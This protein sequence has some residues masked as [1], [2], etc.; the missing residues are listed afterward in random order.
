MA[1]AII[2]CGGPGTAAAAQA[3]TLE[4]QA[5]GQAGK[6]KQEQDQH[7]KINLHFFSSFT[8]VLRLQVGQPL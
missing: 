8:A 7:D 2:C 1:L 5:G 3:P 4:Q 6:R